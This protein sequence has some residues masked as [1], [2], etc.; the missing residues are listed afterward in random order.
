MVNAKQ[1]I[2]QKIREQGGISVQDAIELLVTNG[3]GYETYGDRTGI[4]E[5]LDNGRYARSQE[6]AAKDQTLFRVKEGVAA[7]DLSVLANHVP[8]KVRSIQSFIDSQFSY[9]TATKGTMNPLEFHE[10]VLRPKNYAGRTTDRA[11]RY[12]WGSKQADALREGFAKDES[13]TVLQGL[14]DG[15][16]REAFS[17]SSMDAAYRFE[18]RDPLTEHYLGALTNIVLNPEMTKITEKNKIYNVDSY[19]NEPKE[20]VERSKKN[21]SYIK[22]TLAEYLSLNSEIKKSLN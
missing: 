11:L 21:E 14:L 12:A 18:G 5:D 1:V 17:E 16:L 19:L 7:N 13:A 2:G 9:C 3:R 10:R 8:S 15:A 4:P 6:L 22:P 20:D